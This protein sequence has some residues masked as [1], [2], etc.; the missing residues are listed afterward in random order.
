MKSVTK[1]MINKYK[2]MELGYD[3][4]GYSVHQSDILSFHHLIIPKR[5]CTLEKIPCQGY[6]EWNG[7]IL[8]QTPT[9]N[10]SHDYLHFIEGK[11]YDMF[12]AL[13][14]EMID[15]NL[16]GRLDVKNLET[17]EDILTTFEREHHDIKEV[18]TRRRRPWRR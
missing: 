11:D 9:R 15:E 3:F 14:S 12:C 17:I 18:Y 5:R 10:D 7:A 6:V 4:M 16:K 8:T 2:I 1:L 13:T